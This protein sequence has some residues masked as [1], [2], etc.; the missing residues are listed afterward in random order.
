M[1]RRFV[2]IHCHPSTKP[3]LKYASG[4]N[5][6]GKPS[7]WKEINYKLFLWIDEWLAKDALD[8]QSSLK[9]M[10]KGD[11][12]YFLVVNPVTPMERELA[13]Y[14]MFPLAIK[15]SLPF[16]RQITKQYFESMQRMD[17]PY[18]VRLAEELEFAAE[19]ENVHLM[20]HHSPDFDLNNIN[21]VLAIEG[22]HALYDNPKFE[23][24]TQEI[25]ERLRGLR[26]KHRLLYLTITHLAPSPL[27]NHCF[28]MKNV[29][30]KKV[31]HFYPKNEIGIS[32]TGLRVIDEC[33]HSTSPTCIDVKHMSL[34]ARL[35]F[36]KYRKEK[37]YKVPI[38]AS[39]NGA[40]GL[41]LESWKER[42]L[43]NSNK[44][45][46]TEVDGKPIF[47]LLLKRPEGI[48]LRNVQTVFNPATINLFDEDVEEIVLSDGLIGVSFDERIL[49]RGS[50][51]HYLEVL[52][53]L[54]LKHLLA[55]TTAAEADVVSVQ[56]FNS[57][58]DYYDVK[59][60]RPTLK[61]SEV[62]ARKMK[63][64]NTFMQK[65]ADALYFLNNLLHMVKV[66][67]QTID[68]HGL[69]RDPWQFF[70]LGSDFD[71]VIDAIDSCKNGEK[72]ASFEQLMHQLLT[73]FFATNNNFEEYGISKQQAF[74][75]I[76]EKLNLV[77]HVN[78]VNLIHRVMHWSSN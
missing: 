60:K 50:K 27:S 12:S 64:Q 34:A 39:H 1:S 52:A 11:S 38:F 49:G 78:A 20:S 29:S 77:C 32:E 4:L 24:T 71:G 40:A 68:T 14:T 58:V 13:K 6:K 5:A 56:E 37:G 19:T 3:F 69:D 74:S 45:V 51:S 10:S 28:S 70:A 22:G 46:R 23:N 9:Q 48:K 73:E 41:S 47:S 72:M 76:S 18:A 44:W 15:L 55:F 59:M 62:D 35:Q 75:D 57:Q 36:Y 63:V 30:K 66:A 8:S 61:T 21:L 53:E 54:E 31:H 2:D 43:A 67:K 33:L 26:S 42:C 16:P 65:T 25:V 7:L 17:F